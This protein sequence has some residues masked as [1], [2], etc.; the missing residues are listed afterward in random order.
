ME[1]HYAR[2]PEE[3]NQ[4]LLRELKRMRRNSA[5]LWFPVV[6]IIFSSLALLAV[7]REGDAIIKAFGIFFR[8]R[9]SEDTLTNVIIVSTVIMTASFLVF[10]LRQMV[11]R[12]QL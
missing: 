12:Q 4:S 5:L 9:V 6:L 10:F 3:M 2:V 8:G 1:A 11:Q 7:F